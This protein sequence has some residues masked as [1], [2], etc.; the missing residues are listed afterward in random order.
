MIPFPKGSLS[1]WLKSQQKEDGKPSASILE[2]GYEGNS[3]QSDSDS[4]SLFDSPSGMS[5]ISKPSPGTSHLEFYKNLKK[6]TLKLAEKK[7]GPSDFQGDYAQDGDS[8]T[9]NVRKRRRPKLMMEELDSPGVVRKLAVVVNTD[10]EAPLQVSSEDGDKGNKIEAPKVTADSCEGPE[11]SG[12]SHRLGLSGAN[13]RMLHLLKKAKVQL[14]KIDQQKQL[15]LSQLGSRETRV[16]VTGRRRRRRRVGLPPKD[17]ARQEQPLGGPRIK[18]VCRAAAVALGQPRAMVPDDIPR[19]SALPLH[20]REGI[21]FSPAAED[22]ADDDDDINDQGRTQ[23]VVSQE[24]IQRR[25]RGRGKGHRFRK[26]KIL[27]QYTRGGVRSRRCGRCK[28]CLVEED[29]AKCVNCLDKPKFGGPNTKR[30]CC[31]NAY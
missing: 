20:E 25:R 27:S 10:V 2:S 15:K 21:T 17:V 31:I 9:S 7:K 18:H 24:S 3:L 5:R 13:K 28:G 4:R 6:L 30:Q 19:L 16:P 29:C 12:P 11:V 8:L 23:W 14:I 22:V 26:R 1:T